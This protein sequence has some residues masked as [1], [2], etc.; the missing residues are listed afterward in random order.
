LYDH[1]ALSVTDLDAWIAKLRAEGVTF[2]QE[3]Y[4]LGDTRAVMIEGP[5]REAI[6]LVEI[7]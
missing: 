4:K 5:S 7:R 2:L 6:E 1:V 3:T